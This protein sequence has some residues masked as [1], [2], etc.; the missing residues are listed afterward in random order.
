[1]YNKKTVKGSQ[2][3]SKRHKLKKKQDGQILETARFISY[4]KTS[5]RKPLL[6]N[7]KL[8]R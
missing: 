2:P 3:K 8:F 7:L 6:F 5:A 1:M 4:T